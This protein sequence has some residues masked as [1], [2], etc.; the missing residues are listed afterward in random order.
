MI[1]IIAG[2]VGV[3]GV[4]GFFVVRRIIRKKSGLP[5]FHLLKRGHDS[6][7]Y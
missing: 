7:W 5:V 6:H 3:V 1:L 2:V 4:V